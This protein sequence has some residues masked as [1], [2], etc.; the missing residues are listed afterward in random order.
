M[1]D[2]AQRDALKRLAAEQAVTLVQSGMVVGLGVG[3]T[4]IFAIRRIAELLASGELHDIV[5]IP[6]ALRVEEEAR[7]LGIPLTT[8]EERAQVDVTID[9]A[10]E[11]DPQLNLIKGGGAALLREKIVAQSSLREV[12]VVDEAKLSPVLGTQWAIPVEVV[13][14]GWGAQARWITSLG[15]EVTLRRQP[16][17]EPLTTDQGN[18]ILDCNFGPI[19]DLTSVAT[20]L[21][22]RTGI[23]DHGLFLGL[24]TDLIVAG[25]DGIRH[26][27]RPA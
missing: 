6:C 1:S 24:A 5:G 2:T 11:V 9:G 18:Y 20:Q 13:R 10:D 21:S 15:A 25:A 14:F 26:I 22:L 8:L 12:I 3:S 17:G 4:A 7:R 27:Q 19:A 16:D 23:V